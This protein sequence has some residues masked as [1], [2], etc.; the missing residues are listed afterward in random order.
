MEFDIG[1]EEFQPDP[2]GYNEGSNGSAFLKIG[3]G[4]LQRNSSA[5]NFSTNY[6]VI[7]L[8]QTTTTWQQ[9]RARF[10]QTL[11]GTANGYCCRLEE[12]LI[13]KNDRIVMHYVLT[14]TGTKTFTTEQYLHNFLTFSQRNVGPNYRVYFPYRMT[15]SPEV[16]QWKP[17]ELKPVGRGQQWVDENPPMVSLVNM[18]LYTKTISSVP[19]T[20]IYKPDDYLGPDAIAVEQTDVDQRV[21]IDSS[22]RSAY[23][24]VWTTSYQVS[25][26]QFVIVTLAPG[27]HADYTRTYKFS[28][29]GSMPQ[30]CTGDQIVNGNDLSALCSAWLSEPNGADWNSSCD[31][32]A[33]DMIN[34]KDLAA[35]GH[36]WEND[37]ANPTPAAHWPLDETAGMVA[38]NSV[39]SYDGSLM[40]FSSDDSHW[41]PGHSGGGLNF[42]GTDDYVEV[43]DYKGVCGRNPRTVSAWIKTQPN[44]T[45]N[46]PV[47]AW[48]Q[49]EPGTYWLLEV[50][51]EQRLRLSCGSGFISA[52]EQQVGDGNWHHIALALDPVD[53][54]RP[55]VSDV[56]LYVD[57]KRR[58][59]Y[60]MEEAEINTGC[61]ENVRIGAAHSPDSNYF[62]GTIDEVT[63]FDMAI[64]TTAIHQ[65]YLQLDD[66]LT[67]DMH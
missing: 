45:G 25:P 18:I 30:D 13:V 50:D 59:I 9:D 22:L 15:A 41:V 11:S 34:S 5:Y 2:P 16:T 46:L 23:V 29:D 54:E 36:V 57:G 61:S 42:D 32:S 66:H 35:L 17:P 51:E 49:N 63:I 52:N 56:L 20:W 4:I 37:A 12:D 14:N 64:G 28:A 3:V 67:G 40:G 44:P 43:E 21:V 33:D 58:T 38:A 8:A 19:K 48:G 65:A 26:E 7:E 62:S 55:L 39:G 53:P 6:P 60:K 1:Q 24:G 27:E 31:V 10:V 47:I